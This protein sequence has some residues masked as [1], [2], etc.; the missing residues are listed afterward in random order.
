MAGGDLKDFATRLPLSADSRRAEFRA[1]IE[2]YINPSV[3]ALQN[4]PVPV[5]ACVQGACAGFGLSL[6]LGCDLVLAAEDAY[7]TTAYSSIALSGDG[8]VSWFLPRLVGTRKAFEL[9]LL[10]ERFDAAEAQ[11]LGLVNRVLPLAELEEGLAALLARLQGMPAGAAG[12]IK[13]LLKASATQS[14]GS[15]LQLEA[16]AFARCAAGPD[17]GEGVQAFL[18]RR[19]PL[20]NQG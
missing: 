14:L 19:K 1:L 13:A 5:V 3:L 18:A 9:L 4:L 10:A 8:G 6:I 12:E 16:E 15:Q 2:R 7:F 17:F 20:F 11:R